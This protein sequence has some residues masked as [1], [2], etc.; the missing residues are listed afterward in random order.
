LWVGPHGQLW[1]GASTWQVWCYQESPGSPE[2]L[3]LSWSAVG[4]LSVLPAGQSCSSAPADL[5]KLA[6]HCWTRVRVL[7]QHFRERGHAPLCPHIT[8]PLH[9]CAARSA[10]YMAHLVEVQH[11]RGASGGQ[12]FHSLLTA[13]LPPRRGTGPQPHC[14]APSCSWSPQ[15]ILGQHLL[16]AMG[17]C[18]RSVPLVGLREG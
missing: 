7:A 3:I 5:G 2:G 13:S 16:L 10:D 11:E 18:V 14:V 4:V 8:P 12:T 9:A 6:G 1:A 17:L 15:L